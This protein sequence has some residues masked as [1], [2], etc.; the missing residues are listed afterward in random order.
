MKRL[1]SALPLVEFHSLVQDLLWFGA[2]LLGLLIAFS[3][4]TK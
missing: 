4:T 2:I 3:L 1:R